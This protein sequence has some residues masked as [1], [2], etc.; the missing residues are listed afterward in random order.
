[1]LLRLISFEIHSLMGFLNH[2]D[3]VNQASSWLEHHWGNISV[4]MKLLGPAVVWIKLRS[5]IE[6][7]EVL[8]CVAEATD[9][10]FRALERWMEVLGS[11]PLDCRVRFRGVPLHVWKEEILSVTVDSIIEVDPLTSKKEF[12]LFGRVKIARDTNQ[13]VPQKIYLWLEDLCVPIA[14]GLEEVA[15]VGGEGDDG[16]Q[17]LQ[18]RRP[19]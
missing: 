17:G 12:L 5:G 8:Q 4:D 1:M 9:S 6:V 14:L 13:T 3:G 2:G 7:S 18:R 19:R 10:P 16:F 11:P 15:V